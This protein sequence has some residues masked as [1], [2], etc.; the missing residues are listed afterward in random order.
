M[1]APIPREPR[2]DHG[3]D[4]ERRWSAV[5]RVVRR[6]HLYL[7]LFLWPFVLLFAITGLS[8]NHPTVG[9]GLQ[10]V[11]LGAEEVKRRTGFEP[12][13]PATI[14]ADVVRELNQRGG[15]YTLS[16]EY[17]PRFDGWP[18]F[19]APSEHGR[20][21]LLV[22]LG[23]GSATITD[24]PNAR[25][26]AAAPLVDGEIPLERYSIPALAERLTPLLE[27]APRPTTGP[28]RPHP[29]THPELRFRVAD[30]TGTTWDVVY[31][32][33]A[34]TVTGKKV[35][36]REQ[37]L[38]ELLEA[39]HKQH[40]YPV[41]RD[42]KWLWALFADATAL[43]LI[44]WALSGLFMWFQLKRLRKPGAVVLALSLAVA[45][46]VILGVATD[47]SFA[48]AFAEK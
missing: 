33:T 43:T 7:G 17:A 26:E 5:K 48:G 9:R 14:A 36:P 41:E 19:A 27:R 18:L 45:A 31:D 40:H 20:Q 32:L 29:T 37:P 35:G 46:F 42:A 11:E 4:A 2:P 44:V 6:V 47:L 12:W 1:N 25:G 39:I 30:A 28:L 10:R 34:R 3:R 16:P 23:D 22:S 38:V 13:D 21:A 24:R 8:F 15:R